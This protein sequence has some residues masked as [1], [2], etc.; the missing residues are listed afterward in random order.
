M[1]KLKGTEKQIAWAEDIRRRNIEYLEEVIKRFEIRAA[2]TGQ[3]FP[4]VVAD[5]HRCIH[6][7]KTLEDFSSAKWWIEHQKCAMAFEQ[8]LLKY[9][10][11]KYKGE[12]K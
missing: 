11:N 12:S 8:R 7:F 9:H 1:I 10:Q 5:L 4:E 2:A 6:E 3:N